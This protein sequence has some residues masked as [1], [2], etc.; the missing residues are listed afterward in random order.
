MKKMMWI[1]AV[2]VWPS[3]SFAQSRGDM[4]MFQGPTGAMSTLAKNNQRSTANEQTALEKTLSNLSEEGQ[5]FKQVIDGFKQTV[6]AYLADGQNEADV[7][8]IDGLVAELV[9]KGYMGEAFNSYLTIQK[10]R[11]ELME[12]ALAA[13]G[14]ESTDNLPADKKEE[15]V[16]LIPAIVRAYDVK[17]VNTQKHNML[18]ERN[19]L[20]KY[21]NT[22]DGV[23]L[24]DYL[25][26]HLANCTLS[27]DVQE[28]AKQWQQVLAAA[29]SFTLL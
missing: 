26:D 6:G 18:K 7:A 22:V 12:K 10:N 1:L 8:G 27:E 2:L 9:C 19:A 13:P 25:N 11:I 5:A 23:N 15:S 21:L 17:R 28:S 29:M 24:S 4:I 16:G 3:L 20:L 14:A